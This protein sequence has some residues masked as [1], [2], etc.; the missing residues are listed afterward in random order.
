MRSE[1]ILLSSKNKVIQPVV[2]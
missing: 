2:W 1:L